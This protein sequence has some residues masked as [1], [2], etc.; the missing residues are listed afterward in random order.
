LYLK[1]VFIP[2][3]LAQIGQLNTFQTLPMQPSSNIATLRVLGFCTLFLLSACQ[4]KSESAF[5]ERAPAPPPPEQGESN[6]KLDRAP[7]AK[8]KASTEPFADAAAKR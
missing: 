8:A 2:A 5:A 6:A 7:G 1:K 3:G 4:Q